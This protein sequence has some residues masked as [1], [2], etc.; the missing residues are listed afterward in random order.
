M[1]E[2]GSAY[3]A[4]ARFVDVEMVLEERAACFH[5]V[6]HEAELQANDSM[7]PTPSA[8]AAAI[9]AGSPSNAPTCPCRPPMVM[10]LPTQP[11]IAAV[12]NTPMGTLMKPK[13]AS[14]NAT[15]SRFLIW[16]SQIAPSACTWDTMKSH[17][18]SGISPM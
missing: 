4:V 15:R 14:L 7:E 3:A 2:T 13:P 18:R 5:E 11:N 10:G 8:T 16:A 17:S 1:P 12:Q 9:K 6:V